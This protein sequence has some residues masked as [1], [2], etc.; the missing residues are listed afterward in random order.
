M[1]EQSR[2]GTEG[3]RWG[4]EEEQA[5]KVDSQRRRKT[6]NSTGTVQMMR[7]SKDTEER[8]G[9]IRCVSPLKTYHREH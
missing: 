4:R 2:E 6:A 9:S 3:G 7:N 8:K 5:S 1:R